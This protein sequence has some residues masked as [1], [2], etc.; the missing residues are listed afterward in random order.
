MS[1]LRNG[2][3]LA[4]VGIAAFLVFRTHAFFF[5]PKGVLVGFDERYLAP[6]GVRM[7]DGLALP[8]VDA[9]SHRGPLLYWAVALFQRIVGPYDWTAL[10]WLSAICT[11]LTI[12][13]CF[14]V[15]IS[16]RKPLAGALGALFFA[17]VITSVIET[18]AGI[19]VNGELVA[20]PFGIAALAFVTWGL[21]RARPRTSLF[22]LVLGGIAAGCAGMAKQTSFGVI[23]PLVVWVFLV[24]HA[25]GRGTARSVGALLAGWLL[26]IASIVGVYAVRGY[27]PTFWYWF[28]GYN[29]RIYM[30]PYPRSESV[31]LFL[32]GLHR[33]PF[34]VLAAAFPLVLG[35]AR[36]LASA[37]SL[38]FKE[39]ARSSHAHGLEAALAWTTAFTLLA[40]CS[41]LRFWPHYFVAALAYLCLL[42]G[43]VVESYVG[44]AT[45][46][47]R[48]AAYALIAAVL[49]GFFTVSNGE[50]L[51]S[52]VD[53][54]HRRGFF[55]DER[56]NPICDAVRQ[57]SRPGDYLFVWG[58]DGDFYIDCRRKPASRFVF[59]TFVAGVLAPF[60]KEA[61]PTR[62]VPGAP[63]LLEAD[64]RATRPPVILDFRNTL[65][66]VS[67]HDVPQLARFL[68]EGYCRLGEVR[69]KGR[70]A[71]LWVRKQE[72]EECPAR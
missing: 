56:T 8:Y 49:A 21:E 27:L 47:S 12:A 35:I 69:G 67:M 62:V 45:T 15:G 70:T 7:L 60:W 11:G 63:E 5:E 66:N 71:G 4:I 48:L 3:A 65:A 40:A 72:G 37:A 36:P 46:P 61:K 43:F 9:V 32:E 17:Y 2:L 30:E 19:G 38:S 16:A 51:A 14:A 24:A 44:R 23:V 57:Y 68:D 64:L 31:R 6:F 50:R 20:T 26:P 59:T 13:A 33:E 53:Q 22:W 34:F 1:R 39:I 25:L 29:A 10:R 42:A 41:P 58:F 54:R 55:L 28:Y 18:G 52:L